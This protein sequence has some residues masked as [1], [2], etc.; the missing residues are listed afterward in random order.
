MRSIEILL[1]F[2]E[3]KSSEHKEKEMWVVKFA[4]FLEMTL[5]KVFNEIVKVGVLN[6]DRE[7]NQSLL[8]QTKIV[9]PIVDTDFLENEKSGDIINQ[10]TEK[11][12][13]SL[14]DGK[15]YE[16][17]ILIVSEHL[18]DEKWDDLFKGIHHLN[19]SEIDLQNYLPN[20]D[21]HTVS[22]KNENIFWLKMYDLAHMIL[23]RQELFGLKNSNLDKNNTIY[24]AKVTPDLRNLRN[25]IKRDLRRHGF[26][27]IP[28]TN[29]INTDIDIEE[30]IKSQIQKSSMSLHL[31][32]EEYG[33]IVSGNKSIIDVQNT[34]ADE[35]GAKVNSHTNKDKFF[36]TIWLT[37]TTEEVSEEV[38]IFVSNINRDIEA[39]D[40]SEFLQLPFE[41]LKVIIR[42]RLKYKDSNKSEYQ[43]TSKSDGSSNVY[44][45]YDRKDIESSKGL[46]EALESKGY[47]VSIPVFDGNLF[48]LEPKHINKLKVCDGCLVFVDKANNAWLNT[49]LQDIDK[50]KGM[51]RKNTV[52]AKGVFFFNEL[53][54][55]THINNGTI[56]MENDKTSIKEVLE[57]FIQK[58][59]I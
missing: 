53:P 16:D 39:K 26:T 56:V 23:N 12:G 55:N 19:F 48:E 9:L 21:N 46:K 4:H 11:N 29:L 8:N 51:G 54:I 57:P 58:L 15:R 50:V 49:K 10:F 7:I 3:K 22:T 20:L 47:D 45:I 5:S 30:E 35:H 27:V 37:P 2:S 41:E 18:K 40:G 36:R 13:E 44:L 52:K 42:D 33:E 17:I 1:V 32:G 31:I 28:H 24:L 14:K 59:E 38:E 25:D 43:V 34:L 6:I